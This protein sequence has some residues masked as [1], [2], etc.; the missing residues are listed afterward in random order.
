MNQPYQRAIHGTTTYYPSRAA[1]RGPDEKLHVAPN[2]RERR[3]MGKAPANHFMQAVPYFVDSEGKRIGYY[4]GLLMPSLIRD[5][6]LTLKTNAV[7]HHTGTAR[8]TKVSRQP[9]SA[10][11]KRIKR[12]LGN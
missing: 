3:A 10:K 9:K 6:K 12:T 5:G 7:W 11:S 4:D 8:W 1:F 2:R